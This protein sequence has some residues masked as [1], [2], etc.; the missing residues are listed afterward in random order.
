MSYRCVECRTISE[1]GEY[2]HTPACTIGKQEMGRLCHNPDCRVEER[3]GA[4]REQVKIETND[5]RWPHRITGQTGYCCTVCGEQWE[6]GDL[7]DSYERV[8]GDELGDDEG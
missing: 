5:P 2:K 3:V 7:G 1:R 4:R 8:Y 6:V